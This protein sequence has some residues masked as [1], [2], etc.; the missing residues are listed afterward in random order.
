MSVHVCLTIVQRASTPPC[1][2][3]QRVDIVRMTAAHQSIP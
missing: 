1:S 2:G 3:R